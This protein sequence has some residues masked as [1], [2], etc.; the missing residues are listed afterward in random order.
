M[1]IVTDRIASVKAKLDLYEEAVRLLGPPRSVSGGTAKWCCPWHEERTPS[2]GVNMQGHALEGKWR[3]WGACAEGGDVLDFLTKM[4]GS[5]LRYELEKLG[6][7]AVTRHFTPPPRPTA[8]LPQ[9]PVT[10]EPVPAS[11]LLH[12][13]LNR[14]PGWLDHRAWDHDLAE[15]VGLEFVV[16]GRG[17]PRVRFPFR[18]FSAANDPCFFQ[19]RAMFQTSTPKWLAPRGTCPCPFEAWRISIARRTRTVFICEG[20]P[21][22][23]ALLHLDC[24]LPVIGVPGAGAFKPHWSRAFRGINNF[25]VLSDND[26]AGEKMREQVA[27]ILDAVAHPDDIHQLHIPDP[28]KDV[29]EWRAADPALFP[30]HFAHVLD[31]SLER[32]HAA[33][34]GIL[35]LPMGRAGRE[36]GAE[37]QAGTYDGSGAIGSGHPAAS[38][39]GVGPAP[40]RLNLVRSEAEDR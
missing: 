18:R 9:Q 22:V 2:F 14:Y 20:L 3:C 28:F 5:S 33:R 24:N 11:T 19:D 37:T 27:G 38:M 12:P 31:S 4:N 40:R 8:E 34:A 10:P 17:Q 15:L 25:F 13:A 36:A 23:L 6:G 21:D 30:S 32:D 35:G 39:G 29:D 1:A 16:D 26:R 7:E